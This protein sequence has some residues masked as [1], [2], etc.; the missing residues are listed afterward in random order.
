MRHVADDLG[1]GVDEYPVRDVR[2]D[3]LIGVMSIFEF[4]T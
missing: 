3:A 1:A 4:M 2:G